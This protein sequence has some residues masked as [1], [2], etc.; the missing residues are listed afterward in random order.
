MAL[1]RTTIRRA[2]KATLMLWLFFNV[3]TVSVAA[4]EAEQTATT[5]QETT[6]TSDTGSSEQANTAT[7]PAATPP[8]PT[9]AATTQTEHTETPTATP[10]ATPQPAD[11]AEATAT[12]TPTPE[13][14]T[15]TT[16]EAV[17]AAEILTAANTNESTESGSLVDQTSSCPNPQGE[18]ECPTDLTMVNDN[19]ASAAAELTITA[20]TGDNQNSGN[21]GAASTST[22]NAT[23]T[24]QET[25]VLNENLLTLISASP[26][27]TPTP[28]PNVLVC[29]EEEIPEPT[30]NQQVAGAMTEQN[31]INNNT[32][33]DTNNVTVSASSGN[34]IS[35]ENLDK[36]LTETGDSLAL[37]EVL[38]VINTN[39][40]SSQVAIVHLNLEVESGTDIDLNDVWKRIIAIDDSGMLQVTDTKATYKLWM[41]VENGNTADLVNTI[42]VSAMTGSNTSNG[43]GSAETETGDAKAMAN[44]T[45]IVNTNI[46]GSKFVWGTVNIFAPQSVNI[47]FPRPTWFTP[48]PGESPQGDVIATNQNAAVVENNVSSTANSGNNL[49]GSVSGKTEVTTGGATAVVN[50]VNVVNTDIALNRWFLLM[51]NNMGDWNGKIVGWNSPTDVITPEV[52][53]NIFQA[54]TNGQ[55]NGESGEVTSNPWIL[56]NKNQATVKNDIQVTASTGGNESIDN[57]ADVS[58]KT[59][60][61][62][63][64]SNLLNIVNTNILGSRWFWANVNI[65]GNWSG[66]AVFAYPDISLKINKGRDTVVPGDHIQYVLRMSNDGQDEARG[67]KVKL[68]LPP[69]MS[70]VSDTGNLSGGCQET[71]C[72]WEVGDLQKKEATELGV[73][74]QVDENF[75]FDKKE[76]FWAKFVPSAK[77][78]EDRKN[79]E[80]D[81]NGYVYTLDPETDTTNNS[82]SAVSVVYEK[83][84]QAPSIDQRQPVLSVEAKNNVNGF[85][86][87]GDTVTFEIKVKNSGPVT[88]YQS[89]LVQKVYDASGN[90]IGSSLFELGKIDAGKGGKMNFGLTIPIKAPAG[91]YKTVA[92]VT[93]IAPNGN[94]ISSAEASTWF[95]IKA[96]G[97]AHAATSDNGLTYGPFLEEKVLGAATNEAGPMC[98]KEDDMWLFLM[99]SMYSSV[100]FG[101]RVTE[102]KENF[103]RR[104]LHFGRHDKTL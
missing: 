29:T 27:P 70:F 103:L 86:Y 16:G 15:I 57:N 4:Q 24:G 20:T 80:I 55:A 101:N 5:Q 100:L 10:T 84:S 35:S 22:G 12:P 49:A 18:T 83:Q 6:T 51:L 30:S 54:G 61:A 77:A 8:D 74:L 76:A 9:P 72:S 52:G 36:V 40:V 28:T 60:T 66:D 87:P 23:A 33:S 88:S 67:V 42:R 34:N 79:M 53:V 81:V 102:K 21:P 17:A 73:T 50:S 78:A 56:S 75:S 25:T 13:P 104:L 95:S 38:N 82:A 69:G 1:K 45:N 48:L 46:L 64:L 90:Y 7:T 47:I 93:G 85:V 63:A 92:Q 68:N 89:V 43:N 39:V 37:A 96:R 2:S 19:T 71:S 99:L 44:V 94:S 62:K 32:A 11:Q 3:M 31:L 59:G 97:T 14:S 26:T 58:I 41:S 91:K 98:D 65:L